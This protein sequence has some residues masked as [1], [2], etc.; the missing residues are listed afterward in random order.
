MNRKSKMRIITTVL[1]VWA[2]ASA[3]GVLSFC[4]IA[5]D[6]TER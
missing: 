2:L 1:V 5:A 3:I 6:S 4:A